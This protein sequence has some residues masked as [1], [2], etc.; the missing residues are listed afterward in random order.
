MGSG[1]AKKHIEGN[2]VTI[3]AFSLQV[4]LAL[5]AAMKAYTIHIKGVRPPQACPSLHPPHPTRTQVAA[6]T[7]TWPAQ[8][9]A[10]KATLT[11]LP[12]TFRRRCRDA[13]SRPADLLW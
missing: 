3:I 2:D 8:P 6:L 11:I 9:D 13:L 1:Q 12:L 4:K 10:L 5:E 7:P